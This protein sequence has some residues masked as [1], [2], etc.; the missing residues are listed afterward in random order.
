MLP[1]FRVHNLRR[2]GSPV[3]DS[4]LAAF[5]PSLYHDGTVCISAREYDA[6]ISVHPQATLKYMDEDDGDIITVGSL[7]Y[8]TLARCLHFNA[9]WLV[10]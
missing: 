9:D 1:R 2:L 8:C 4:R 7:S 6:T 10:A 5:P 3:S